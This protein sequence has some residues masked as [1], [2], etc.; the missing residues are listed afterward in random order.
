MQKI[1]SSITLEDFKTAQ[2]SLPPELQTVRTACS[3]KALLDWTTVSDE[4][5]AVEFV[6]PPEDLEPLIASG[7]VRLVHLDPIGHGWHRIAVKDGKLREH[8][9]RLSG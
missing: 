2:K 3:I 8:R 4:D 5:L 9:K 1:P 7:F 6:I